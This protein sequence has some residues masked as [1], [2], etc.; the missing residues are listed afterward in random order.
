M[1]LLCIHQELLSFLFY[2]ISNPLYLKLG[3]NRQRHEVKFLRYCMDHTVGKPSFEV[4][5]TILKFLKMLLNLAI[6]VKEC[7]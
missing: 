6:C 2:R 3:L 4:N 7:D 1:M 5:Y